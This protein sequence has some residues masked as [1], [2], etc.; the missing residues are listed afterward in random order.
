[1]VLLPVPVGKIGGSFP[2]QPVVQR[3]IL[4]FCG[5]GV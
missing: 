5:S 1:M 4:A 2:S 3:S